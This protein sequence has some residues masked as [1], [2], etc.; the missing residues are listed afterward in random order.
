MSILL[1][2][3]NTTN[4]FLHI[5]LDFCFRANIAIQISTKVVFK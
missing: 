5:H 3:V 4:N 2:I 1:N